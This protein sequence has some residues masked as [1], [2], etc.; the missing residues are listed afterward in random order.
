[1]KNRLLFGAFVGLGII[2][3]AQWPEFFTR[4]NNLVWVVVFALA[5]FAIYNKGK[6]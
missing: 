5:G 6:A 1:M 2:I 3:G 4:W